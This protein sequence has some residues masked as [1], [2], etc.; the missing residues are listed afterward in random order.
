MAAVLD[1]VEMAAD[2]G[3]RC[4]RPGRSLVKGRGAGTK[5]TKWNIDVERTLV[6]LRGGMGM[7]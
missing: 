6:L 4:S 2:A 3:I 7:G 1:S 5:V